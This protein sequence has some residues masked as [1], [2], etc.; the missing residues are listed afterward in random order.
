MAL[1]EGTPAPIHLPDEPKKAKQT[2]GEGAN[3]GD[4]RAIQG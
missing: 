4:I 1:L 3:I 2:A